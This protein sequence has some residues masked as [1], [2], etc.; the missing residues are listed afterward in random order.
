M[1]LIPLLLAVCLLLGTVPAYSSQG[2]ATGLPPRYLQPVPTE[3]YVPYHRE[4]KGVCLINLK[5]LQVLLEFEV[6]REGRV[7]SVLVQESSADQAALEWLLQAAREFRFPQKYVEWEPQ[8]YTTV[9]AFPVRSQSCW[10][11]P[12]HESLQRGYRH[13]ENN[14]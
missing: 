13:N 6:G 3:F 10:R 2:P 14:L 12:L 1:K 4:T 7:E 11:P 5:P 9:V 8:P